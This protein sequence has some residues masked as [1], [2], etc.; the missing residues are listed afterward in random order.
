MLGEWKL[1]H[2]QETFSCKTTF[3]KMDPSARKLQESLNKQKKNKRK[4]TELA[5]YVHYMH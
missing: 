4:L 2:V 1:P 5:N 3:I